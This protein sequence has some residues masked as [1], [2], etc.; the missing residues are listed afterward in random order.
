MAILP[1]YQKAGL[2]SFGIHHS[3]MLAEKYGIQKVIAALIRNGAPSEVLLK[4]AESF[5]IW[6]HRYAVFEKSI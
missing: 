1:E 6:E 4:R 2:A 3:L 5:L